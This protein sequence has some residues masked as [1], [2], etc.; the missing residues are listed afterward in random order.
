MRSLFAAF[1]LFAATSAHAAAGGSLTFSNFSMQSVDLNADD[2]I[3]PAIPFA[4]ADVESWL[5]SLMGNASQLTGVVTAQSEVV[6]SFDFSYTLWYHD[7]AGASAAID[8]EAG[9]WVD[10][11]P[12][13]LAAGAMEGIY[14]GWDFRHY[15]GSLHSLTRSYS[16]AFRILNEEAR[17]RTFTLYGG[18][19]ILTEE[20]EWQEEPPVTPVPE[21]ATYA[22]LLAGLAL[23]GA[24]GRQLRRR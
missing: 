17:E 1:I 23:V 9:A 13:Q 18:A 3:A 10:G 5:D 24:A 15:D 12:Y 14:A 11:D 2:G 6:I 22:M 21:P 7:K 19:A 16:G 20:G 8:F 4:A